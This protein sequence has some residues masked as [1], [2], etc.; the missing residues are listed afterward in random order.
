MECKHTSSYLNPKTP[1]QHAMLFY[2]PILPPHLKVQHHQHVHPNSLC[3]RCDRR[4]LP[5]TSPELE[6]PSLSD[7]ALDSDL[8]LSLL[9]RRRTHSL[10]QTLLLLQNNLQTSS[11]RQHHRHHLRSPPW[12]IKLLH[13]IQFKNNHAHPPPQPWGPHRAPCEGN[14]EWCSAN[15][16]EVQLWPEK[17]RLS[18][19]LPPFYTNLDHVLQW[20][21][22]GVCHKAPA[23]TG[24]HGCSQ[25]DAV[26]LRRRWDFRARGS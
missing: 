14:A 22:G 1:T 4:G 25:I 15:R 19:F 13:P 24:R 5:E 3:P 11:H 9:W 26:Y 2:N 18:L 21:E 8:R 16:S 23:I 17:A 6:P 10:Q 12:K 20:K 7:G